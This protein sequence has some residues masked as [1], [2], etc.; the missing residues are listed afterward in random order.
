[1]AAGL[2]GERYRVATRCQMIATAT[3][4]LHVSTPAAVAPAWDVVVYGSSPAGVAAA[5]AAGTLGLRVALYEPLP[6]IG[7]MGAAG[8]LVLH[9]GG[10]N[11]ISGLALKFAQLNGA[12]YN[13][14]KPVQ[15]PESFVSN[16][17]FYTMLDDAGVTHVKLDCHVTAAATVEETETSV[18]SKVESMTV[19]CEKEPVTATVFIDA[20]YDGDLMVAAGNIPFTAGRESSAQYNESLAGARVP[21]TNKDEGP[22]TIDAMS[23]D[24]KSFIKYV[25]NVST[26]PPA[27][28]ADDALMA[29]QHR[30]CIAG[31]ENMVPWPKPSGY[32]R[33]DFLIMQRCV[34]A[35][36]GDVMSG[37]P[38]SKFKD[39]GA[40]HAATGKTKYIS[41][42]GINVCAGD[43]PNLNKGWA[44]ANW[45]RRQEIIAD[46]TYFEMGAYYYLAHDVTGPNAAA[47]KRKFSSYGLCADEY[48]AFQ[49]IPPQ[50]YVR[51][52][53]RMVG[54]YVMTQNNIAIPMIKHDSIAVGNWWFDEHMT[55]KYAMPSSNK[56]SVGAAA[57]GWTVQLEGNF[58]PHM[59]TVF[60]PSKTN[61][62]F[63]DVPYKIMVPKRG[64]GGN[65][66]VPVA[67]SASA[68]AYSS[69]RI[70][71]MFMAVGSAAGVA[72]KQLVD[73]DVETVQDVDVA[74]VQSILVSGFG[75]QIH[76]A[77]AP[78]PVP[79][80][81]V[82][83]SYTVVGA[84]DA[85]WN[86][87]YDLVK[88]STALAAA[89]SPTYALTSNATRSIYNAMG[90]WRIAVH[91]VGL[92]YTADQ[93]TPSQLP[94]AKG[95]TPAALGK[96]PAPTLT[97]G[98]AL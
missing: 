88:T 6:M 98:P 66:L 85:S 80:Q 36:Y 93:T 75:Q 17:S 35:G 91:G 26:L 54:D 65:L 38:P 19:I 77:A 13:T 5:A 62:D 96:A 4:L 15:Q 72:A 34:D 74:K 32:H 97:A 78:S 55:G 60:G 31:E 3:L 12:Y 20:S 63:Y 41:C 69:T 23:P 92:A 18:G 22:R 52:S 64:V 43:Q 8:L 1:M 94:P 24:G 28:S 56:S 40:M 45:E 48:Q 76:V 67:L 21:G 44:S 46:H 33:E 11:A 42:C 86:G 73:G 70:E 87:K 57:S 95:W 58:D 81:D 90:F 16:A 84:G 29:F 68:V 10:F 51:I 14:T 30:L 71:S 9:D 37:M 2:V 47:V 49:N 50:L 7:G 59:P 82:P 39:G 53:N 89:S 79:P 27:G 25:Q 61:G 83:K